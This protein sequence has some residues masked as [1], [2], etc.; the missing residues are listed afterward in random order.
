VISIDGRN[1]DIDRMKFLA[2][3]APDDRLGRT[4]VR[5]RNAILADST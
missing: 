5:A 1:N 2:T 3:S 4:L